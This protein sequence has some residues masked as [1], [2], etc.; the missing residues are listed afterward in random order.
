MSEIDPK[1][2]GLASLTVFKIM[3]G[4]L[5]ALM[6][7]LGS[8]LNLFEAVVAGH[9]Q[10]AAEIAQAAGLQERWVTE[11]LYAVA[12]ANLVE[13]DGERFSMTREMA[14][15][16]ADETHP[17]FVGPVFAGPPKPE[18]VD[19]LAESFRTGVGHTWDTHGAGVAAMQQAMNSNATRAFL[20]DEVIA[21]IPGLTEKLKAGVRLI[22]IGCGAGD[23]ASTIARA[24]PNT[25][26]LGID[27]SQHALDLAARETDGI[28]NLRFE[29]GTFDDMTPDSADVITTFD[30]LHDLPFPQKAC[31][32]VANALVTGGDWLV[33]D[34]K[35]GPDF[36]SNKRN[37]VRALMYS[38][39]VAYCMNSALSEPGGAGLG[40]L[41]MHI[42][43]LTELAGIAGFGEP[44]AYEFDFDSTNRYFHLSL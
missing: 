15:V 11:W 30:V 10:T 26:V 5:L 28:D 40:T 9:G 21:A 16:L 7:H 20:V 13:F 36:D 44:V 37:P 12:A 23:A 38:M 43:K 27:P 22:D 31:G 1:R 2:L 33:S 25:T 39:S 32:S 29:L 41:G 8:R 42:G 17:S 4:E 14:A 3:E 6:L 34:I 19:R 18:N 24:F 35:A